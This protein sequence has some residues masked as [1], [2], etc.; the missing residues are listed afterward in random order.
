MQRMEKKE[1]YYAEQEWKWK[2]IVKVKS[3]T[4]GLQAISEF[5][6]WFDAT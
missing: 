3:K 4:E 1:K 6:S 2:I 5:S